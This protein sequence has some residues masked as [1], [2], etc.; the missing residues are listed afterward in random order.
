MDNP[1]WLRQLLVAPSRPMLNQEWVVDPKYVQ[2]IEIWVEYFDATETFDEAICTYRG[3]EG[4]A[5]PVTPWE[6]A[7]CS[8]FAVVAL[9][10]AINKMEVYKIGA[11]VFYQAKQSGLEEHERKWRRGTPYSKID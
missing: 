1:D 8:R 5:M 4:F 10:R 7:A 2:A 11:D 6:R 3:R 9:E